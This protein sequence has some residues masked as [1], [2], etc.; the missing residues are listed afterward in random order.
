MVMTHCASVIYAGCKYTAMLVTSTDSILAHEM[1]T[2]QPTC[3]GLLN[4]A[5]KA[6]PTISRFREAYATQYLTAE[7]RVDRF[8]SSQRITSI[9]QIDQ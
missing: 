4:L 5:N 7:N 9:L 1:C 3:L 8:T 2:Y 6:A